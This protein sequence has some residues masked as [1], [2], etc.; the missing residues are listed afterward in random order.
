MRNDIEEIFIHSKSLLYDCKQQINYYSEIKK[1]LSGNINNYEKIIIIINFFQIIL[2]VS[3]TLFESLKSYITIIS[4][5]HKSMIPIILSASLSLFISFSK[6]FQFETTLASMG[7]IDSKYTFIISRLRHKERCILKLKSKNKD[8]I[9]NMLINFD[10]DTLD[11]YIEITL[12]E[13]DLKFKNIVM[14][15]LDTKSI[16]SKQYSSKIANTFSDTDIE[17]ENISV[18]SFFNK[19]YTFFKKKHVSRI[20]IVRNELQ[21][22]VS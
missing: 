20:N 12:N 5:L 3:I 9:D 18:K 6:Y 7:N 19:I 1:K 17:P 16:L 13:T 10:N 15:N 22:N 8:E 11:S 4:E 21:R 14:K 2:P